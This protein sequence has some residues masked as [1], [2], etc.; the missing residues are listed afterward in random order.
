MKV[1]DEHDKSMTKS[2]IGDL[3][4]DW[5]TVFDWFAMNFFSSFY[6][7]FW[8]NRHVVAFFHS[9][10]KLKIR[11]NKIKDFVFI[12]FS[13]M[14]QSYSTHSHLLRQWS[15]ILSKDIF[16]LLKSMESNMLFLTRYSIEIIFTSIN[17]DNI[18]NNYQKQTLTSIICGGVLSFYLLTLF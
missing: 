12:F 5:T 4:R 18:F 17:F 11:P 2:D 13:R 7:P 8:Q 1:K 10:V 14:A 6:G 9:R 3:H 16:H 15:F